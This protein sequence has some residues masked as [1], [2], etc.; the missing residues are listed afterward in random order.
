LASFTGNDMNPGRNLL[1]W[2]SQNKWMRNNIPGLFFV[3]KALKRFMPGENIE[4]AMIV[5]MKFKQ[6]GIGTV[7]TRLGEN[8]TSLED[9]EGVTNHYLD[10]LNKIKKQDVPSEISLKLTQIGLDIS[11]DAAGINFGRIVKTA[12]EKNNFVW[13]DMEQSSYVN[14]TID[15]YKNFRADYS[16]IGICLQAYLKRTESDIND[17]LPEFPNIRLVKGAYLEPAHIAYSDK[18]M[19]DDNYFKLAKALLNCSKEKDI[20]VAFATH[21]TNLISRIIDYTSSEKISPERFE[22]QMLYGIKPGEQIRIA[23]KGYK[24]RVLISYGEAWYPWYMRRLA[25]RPANIWFV[26]KNIFIK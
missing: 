19:V 21:D 4:D 11:E 15:F 18:T 8:I 12:S 26:I 13:L 3:K 6:Q 25:E 14:K 7:F 2:A 9:A 1:L 10:V 17:L 5:G 20:R 23:Q 16:N 22:F 24:I